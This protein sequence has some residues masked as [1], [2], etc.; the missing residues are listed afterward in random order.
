MKPFYFF[1]RA[2]STVIFVSSFFT[3]LYYIGLLQLI[4]R[5][6]A[7]LMVI[8]MGKK[9]VSGA[10]A[11]SVTANVFM[12]QTEAPLIVKPYIPRMTK[13]ELLTLMIGG[14]AHISGGLIAVY[15][16]MGANAVAILAT[17][18]MAVPTSLYL[19][20]ILIPET[21]EPVT[22]AKCRRPMKTNTPT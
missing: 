17:S 22:G 10:E 9:G 3:I 4:V 7:Y 12:G 13:S 20:K 14:M 8:V 6:F 11:L 5:F 2:L 18:L 1:F 21:E 16:S 15:I 19:S